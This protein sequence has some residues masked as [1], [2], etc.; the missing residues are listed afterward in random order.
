MPYSLPLGMFTKLYRILLGT[1][2]VIAVF[3]VVSSLSFSERLAEGDWFWY[4]SWIKC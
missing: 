3:F 1:V 2:A 4:D